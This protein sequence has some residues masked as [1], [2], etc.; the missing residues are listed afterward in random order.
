[1]YDYRG[2]GLSQ[3]NETF[4]GSQSMSF[5]PTYES[6]VSDAEAII[7]YVLGTYNSVDIWGSS[8]G[9]GVSTVALDKVLQKRA[10]ALSRLRLFNHDSFTTTTQVVM[11]NW[12]KFGRV[13]G[14]VLGGLIDAETSM[15]NLIA[16][17]VRVII[18]CHQLDPV[19]PVKARMADL[20]R[21][22][23]N[24]WIIYSPYYGHADLSD[25]MI[26]NLMRLP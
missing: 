1:M 12:P 11:P 15:R 23:N 17:G 19:I 7:T 21:N 4:I 18:L 5:R 13:C 3:T 25:D 10:I 16:L 2:T 20:F 6:V 14:S 9:G 22:S 24:V 8:L 26:A